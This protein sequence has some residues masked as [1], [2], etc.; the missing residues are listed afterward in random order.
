VCVGDCH[1]S[2]E[3]TISEL[4]TVVNIA[5]GHVNVTACPAGDANHDGAIT[6]NEIL[7]AVNNA[8]NVCAAV[9]VGDCHDSGEVAISELLTMVNIALGQVNVTA[10]TAGD[11]NHDGT[12]TINEILSAVINALNLCAVVE[13]VS[14]S[15][16][17][18]RLDP[19]PRAQ[20]PTSVL[21]S[22]SA[23]QVDNANRGE[24]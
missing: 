5:L 14:D 4:L 10:C 7:R 11:A 9:C 2:G 22:N 13:L 16:E 12:I 19:P 18:L 15:F 1:G 20:A 8:L 6:I 3:V 24:Q 21:F 17:P 23:G